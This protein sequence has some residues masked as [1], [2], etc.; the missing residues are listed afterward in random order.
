MYEGTHGIGSKVPAEAE[1]NRALGS[2]SPNPCI[3]AL[4]YANDL[5]LLAHSPDNLVVLLGMADAVALKYGLFIYTAKTEIIMI[6]QPMTLPTF[7]LSGKELR[8]TDS[9]KLGV[10]LCG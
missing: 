1:S 5:A 9:F 8:V 2:A 10:F 4:M 3:V 7:K 6:G